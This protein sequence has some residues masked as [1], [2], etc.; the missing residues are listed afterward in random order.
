MSRIA[1][2]LAALHDERDELL[3]EVSRIDRAIAALEDASGTEPMQPATART[4]AARYPP[5]AFGRTPGPY[6]MLTVCEAAA[7]YLAEAGEPKTTAQIAAALK[8]GG[9]RTNSEHFTDTVQKMLRATAV[10]V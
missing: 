5:D 8:A 10:S 1:E 7:L 3:N 4:T 9:F 2:L 6:S